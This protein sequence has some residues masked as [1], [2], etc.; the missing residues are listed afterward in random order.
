MCAAPNLLHYKML[1][2]AKNES[3]LLH[4]L[5]VCVSNMTPRGF[6]PEFQP[7]A[8]NQ[9]GKELTAEEKTFREFRR[10]RRFLRDKKGMPVDLPPRTQSP[11]AKRQCTPYPEATRRS[12]SPTRKEYD[13]E[14][15]VS[16]SGRYSPTQG[17]QD[18][19]EEYEEYEEMEEGNA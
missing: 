1:Q 4:H 15:T 7:T 6:L 13:P 2:K 16:L 8:L 3:T 12:P 5:K 17:E 14:R 19:E 10:I 11:P 9:A 18:E